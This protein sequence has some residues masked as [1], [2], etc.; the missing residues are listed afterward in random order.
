MDNTTDPVRVRRE[1]IRRWS[2]TGKRIGYTLFTMAIVVFA[3]GASGRF[4]PTITT[5]VAACLGVGSV[6]LVPAII[7]AYGVKAADRED[8]KAGRP[9]GRT[10]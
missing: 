3:I 7:F 10:S 4:T 8:R 6:L 1:S 9:T 5:V 2:A